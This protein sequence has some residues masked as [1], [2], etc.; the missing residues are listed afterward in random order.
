MSLRGSLRHHR[1]LGPALSLA[2]ATVVL[3]AGL[4]ACSGDGDEATERKYTVPASL[5]GISVDPSLVKPLLPGGNALSSALSKPNG[6]TAHCDVS[7]DGKAALRLTEAWWDAQDNAAAV[8]AA[9]HGTSGGTASDDYRLVW[10]GKAGI[11]KAASC[12]SSEHPEQHPFAVV[13]VLSPGIDD[14]AA[15]KSL[16]IAYTATIGRSAACR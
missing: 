14:R 13:Q 4:S 12:T 11:G 8:A 6:G 3:A 5:C 7:V 16:V 1:S 2:A 10:A 9:Y 15:V